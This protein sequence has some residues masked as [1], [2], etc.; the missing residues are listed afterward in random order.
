MPPRNGTHTAYNNLNQEEEACDAIKSRRD[1]HTFACLQTEH[2]NF[3]F[4]LILHNYNRLCQAPI[5]SEQILL[6][7]PHRKGLMF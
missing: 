1:L 2:T 5:L 7:I 3:Q 4:R 6:D